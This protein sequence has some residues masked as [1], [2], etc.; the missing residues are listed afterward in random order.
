MDYLI[1]LSRRVAD[2]RRSGEENKTIKKT[3]AQESEKCNELSSALA[4][5]QV[6]IEKL[7][8]NVKQVQE[9]FRAEMI[10]SESEY[11]IVEKENRSLVDKF[12]SALRYQGE[13]EA[14]MEKQVNLC[15]NDLPLDMITFKKKNE[16]KPWNFL[17]KTV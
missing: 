8:L 12:N 15:P 10:K 17:K 2:L 9:K 14:T 4:A 7:Q 16:P 6:T 1:R 3:L 13:L 5:K 11:A